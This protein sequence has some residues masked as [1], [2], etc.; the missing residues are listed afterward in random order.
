MII[1]SFTDKDGNVIETSMFQYNI[2]NNL[3]SSI[4]KIEIKDIN[5]NK[6]FFKEIYVDTKKKEMIGS[7]ISVVLDQ[8]NFG[9]SEKNDPRFVA[10]RHFCVK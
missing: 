5:K 9:V 7:D 10:N 2:T 3:F 1:P 8:E 6:Y 4:G